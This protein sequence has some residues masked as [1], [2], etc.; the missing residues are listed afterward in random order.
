MVCK[1]CGTELKKGAKY[2]PKCGHKILLQKLRNIML[3]IVPIFLLIIFLIIGRV[4]YLIN[5]QKSIKNIENQLISAAKAAST[6]LTAEE[7]DRYHTIEDTK[8]Q[9]YQE[10]KKRLEQ[11][12]KENNVRYVYYLRPGQDYWEYIIDNDF[13]PETSV[14]PWEKIDEFVININK[15]IRD[16]LHGNVTTKLDD[17]E[18]YSGFAPVYDKDNNVYCVVGVDY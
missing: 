11:F 16:A 18:V 4:F 7:L 13:N 5:Q 14:G 2:C 12:A 1:K 17:W 9:S 10:L 3:I 15:D 6:F 8:H